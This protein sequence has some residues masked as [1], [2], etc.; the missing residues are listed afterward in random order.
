MFRSLVAFILLASLYG[1][2][3]RAEAGRCQDIFFRS[4]QKVIAGYAH[5]ARLIKEVTDQ[6]V[7][8][9]RSDLMS[10]TRPYSFSEL[11]LRLIPV[12][13]SRDP[14]SPSLESRGSD[15][16]DMFSLQ[17]FPRV[18]SS[19]EVL[20]SKYGFS[21]IR[22]S[23]IAQLN[24]PE[25][26]ARVRPRSAVTGKRIDSESWNY[27]RF[28]QNRFESLPRIHLDVSQ[29]PR[30]FV[31]SGK[32]DRTR[33]LP[34]VEI[35][36]VSQT[37]VY[38]PQQNADVLTSSRRNAQSRFAGDE[39]PL[40]LASSPSDQPLLITRPFHKEGSGALTWNQIVEI[41]DRVNTSVDKNLI[42][43]GVKDGEYSIAFPLFKPVDM[44]NYDQLSRREVDLLFKQLDHLISDSDRVNPSLRSQLWRFLADS[45]FL[46]RISE[47]EAHILFYAGGPSLPFSTNRKNISDFEKNHDHILLKRKNYYRAFFVEMLRSADIGEH[48]TQLS[49][50]MNL[51]DFFEI[52]YILKTE[53]IYPPQYA[54]VLPRPESYAFEVKSAT[55]ASLNPVG[56]QSPQS[57]RT[58]FKKH[59]QNEMNL[60]D[61]TEY[62]SAANDFFRDTASP[63]KIVVRRQSGSYF[64]YNLKTKEFGVINE[65]ME[66]VTYYLVDQQRHSIHEYL[67][68]N[69]LNR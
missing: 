62:L 50:T 39:R 57:L 67:G 53:Q 29:T 24:N 9:S 55:L 68:D 54:R 58:H 16:S 12:L 37:P 18:Q 22:D 43:I 10:S 6:Q 65:R 23:L 27:N 15:I 41:V 46:G 59:G 17:Y 32:S 60:R 2:L 69:L 48:L 26:R 3:A 25:P 42:A 19:H 64:K 40:F 34:L 4:D 49:K 30:E 47:G 28:P 21:L 45:I 52:L 13:G 8:W 31:I 63:H 11:S 61:E 35:T 1:E 44:K 33:S 7:Q 20:F 36:Q 14:L 66:I 38:W 51:D 5:E 56:W